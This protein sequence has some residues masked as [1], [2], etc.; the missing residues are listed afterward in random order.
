MAAEKPETAVKVR[1]PTAA[2]RMLQNEKR[3]LINKGFK[4]RIRSAV[5]K[6]EEILASGEN[7][8]TQ[9]SLREVYS[10][11][12]KGVQKGVIPRNTAGRTKSRLTART[13]KA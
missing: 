10:L 12:D 5:R 1:R 4:S 13:Q 3:R 8:N 2:K 7:A 6:L 9:A 11:L